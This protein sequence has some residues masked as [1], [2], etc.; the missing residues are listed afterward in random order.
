VD[1]FVSV[2]SGG[3]P[4]KMLTRP[5]VFS[6]NRLSVN[7]A[8]SAAGSLRFEMC[9]ANGKPIEGFSLEDS[10]ILFGNEIEHTVNWKGNS[11]LKQLSGKPVCLRVRLHDADLYSVRFVN[12]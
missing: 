6:G 8:T 11:D 4:G 10:E 3:T 1:G 9:E 12:F 7:Y 2:H 5:L